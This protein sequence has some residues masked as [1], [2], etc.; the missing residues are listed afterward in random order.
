MGRYDDYDDYD[1]EELLL[2]HS[3]PGVASFII[4]LAAGIAVG[5]SI[6]VAGIVEAS[7]PGALGPGSSG[8]VMIGAVV[9]LGLLIA[10][11]GLGLGIAGVCQS[12]RKKVFAVIGLIFNGLILL[13][14]GLLALIGIAM[15]EPF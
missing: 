13:G 11:V 7:R 10:L 8:E 1:D 9:C 6:L 15:S 14:G 2:K 5:L 12:N 4:A 3:G